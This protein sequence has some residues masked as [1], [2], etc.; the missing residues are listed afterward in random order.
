MDPTTERVIED[1]FWLVLLMAVIAFFWFHHRDKQQA[2]R[3]NEEVVKTQENGKAVQAP[4]KVALSTC[5]MT[6]G[7]E[8]T[9]KA[10]NKKMSRQTALKKAFARAPK[11]TLRTTRKRLAAQGPLE[12]VRTSR[13]SVTVYELVETDVYGE[14]NPEVDDQEEEFGT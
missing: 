14:S 2:S 13:P 10:K 3:S 7:Y 5:T 12:F 11:K 4:K 8:L 9:S 6:G 1:G